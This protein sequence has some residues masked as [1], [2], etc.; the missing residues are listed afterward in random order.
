MASSESVQPIKGAQFTFLNFLWKQIGDIRELQ[1]SGLFYEALRQTIDLIDY[2]PKDFQNKFE[3]QQKAKKISKELDEI[4]NG[5]ESVDEY[6]H[7]VDRLEALDNYSKG[8]LK[9][10]IAELSIRL[11]EKGYEEKKSSP[12]ERGTV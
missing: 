7:M 4:N 3:F 10:F 1:K 5:V 11:D 9:E 2:L 8:K 12:I 6:T